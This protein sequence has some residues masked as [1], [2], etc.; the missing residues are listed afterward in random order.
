MGVVIAL[1]L[2][3]ALG[4]GFLADRLLNTLPIFTM[5]GLVLGV[6]LAV[7]YTYLKFRSFFRD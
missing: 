6:V 3:V 4:L 1:L 2:V 5:V 7:R